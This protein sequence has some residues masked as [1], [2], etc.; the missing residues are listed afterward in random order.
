M[1]Q[2]I[3]LL[4]LFIGLWASLSIVTPQITMAQASSATSSSVVGTVKDETGAVIV[5]ATVTVRNVN[6][7]FERI[8]Q[9]TEQGSYY[10]SQL[11]PGEYQVIAKASGFSASAIEKLSLALGTT[12]LFDIVLSV[13]SIDSDIIEITSSSLLNQAKTESSTNVDNKTIANL[14][15]NRRDFLE[16]ALTSARVTRDS[17][18]SQG[19]LTTSGLSINGQNPRSNNLT[20]D[21][22]SN[23]EFGSGG[24]L[25]PFSQESVQEFQVITDSFSAEIGRTLAG[26]INI[27]TKSGSN[28]MHGN[29][30]LFYRNNSLSARNAFSDTNPEFKQYRFGST[31]SGAIKQDKAFFFSSFERLLVKQNNIV[32]IS[33]QTLASVVKQGFFQ[34]N[35]VIPFS[36][37]NTNVL[38]RTDFLL[39]NNDTLWIRYNGNSTYNGA[40]E[41][42]G[43]LV[44]D[45]AGGQFRAN[46]H[47]LALNNTYFTSNN[48]VNE[49]R[50]IFSRLDRKTTPTGTQPQIQL[51]APEGNIR[52]GQ[53][54]VLPQQ[55][56]QRLYQL[57]NN[58]STTYK[59]N[60]IKF[61]TDLFYIETLP[62]T[63]INQFANA[64]YS[65][66]PIDFSTITGIA[67][68][69]SFTGLEAFDPTLR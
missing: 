1:R 26:T 4:L 21:G 11:P 7:S 25:S 63:F 46:D 22:L 66:S 27:V 68:L 28:N 69:P 10:L 49:T 45:T 55:T 37:T 58:I 30:F 50:F 14:P 67:N 57:V 20:L 3:K 60:N 62:G 38:V 36:T 17:T 9:I 47:S 16:F 13:K 32:T 61:G 31:L 43:G 35:G 48:L 2:S 64:S 51:V 19:V 41:Q 56:R 18:P 59:N 54:V 5:G 29:V 44:G 40:L 65:F 42:F 33:D 12:A 53:N 15:I 24:R 39:S 52:F 6:T 23:N 34:T 8:A